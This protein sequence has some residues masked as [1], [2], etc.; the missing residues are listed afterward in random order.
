MVLV[1]LI[2]QGYPVLVLKDCSRRDMKGGKS[3]SLFFSVERKSQNI[4]DIQGQYETFCS[5]NP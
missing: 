5:L 1:A 3:M 4:F 2:A